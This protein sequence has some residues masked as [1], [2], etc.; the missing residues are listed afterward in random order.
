MEPGSGEPFFGNA[1]SHSCPCA[2]DIKL[3]LRR[4]TRSKPFGFRYRL[5]YIGLLS[6]VLANGL[7]GAAT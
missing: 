4:T 3:P 1:H 5:L 2:G 7:W 6:F